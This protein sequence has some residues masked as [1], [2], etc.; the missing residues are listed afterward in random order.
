MRGGEPND[1]AGERHVSPSAERNK[2]VIG[3][4]L[5][6]VLPREGLVV[7]ISSGTGQHVVHFARAMPHVSWQPSECDDASL[8]SIARWIEGEGLANVLAPV[9]LDVTETPWP[10]V[11]AAAV[12]CL[13]MIH[14]APWAAG[15]ALIRGASDL[16]Q[17]GGPLFLYGPFMRGGHHTSPSNEAFDRQLRSRNAQWGV[18][19]LD[20]V[21]GF[22][23]AHGFGPPEILE[24]PANN[25]SVVVR[26][27]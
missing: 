18:R 23:R 16:L 5:A 26:R 10:M 14:I 11:S 20:D 6:R 21:A 13:N 17:E 4:V 9:R 25:L 7:E 27:Q 19:N 24:M 22:A 8:K 1:K 2:G 12:V 3:D 15:E